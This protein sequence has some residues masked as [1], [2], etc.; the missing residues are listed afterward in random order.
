ML[1]L[2]TPRNKL[3]NKLLPMLGLGAGLMFLITCA[4]QSPSPTNNAE[5]PGS[6]ALAP[7][8]TVSADAIRPVVGGETYPIGSS[9]SASN[10]LAQDG[11]ITGISVSRQGQA[12]GAP[13]LATV[14]LGVEAFRDTVQSARDD[15]A[16]MKSVIATLKDN[17]VADEDIKTS[18][19]GSTPD[20]TATA[21][22][23]L[24]SK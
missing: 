15:A 10:Q 8:N 9:G 19:F 11:N 5:T 6:Q 7:V 17:G 16:A 2:I 18:R 20:S 24:D 22:T 14:N 21:R 3:R 13:D 23:L 12:S 1:N 4:A